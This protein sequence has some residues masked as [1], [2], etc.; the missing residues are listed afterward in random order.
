MVQ[1]ERRGHVHVKVVDGGPLLI[2]YINEDDKRTAK[3]IEAEVEVLRAFAAAYTRS[4]P[5]S[6]KAITCEAHL[7]KQK[8][9][10][11]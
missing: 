10:G 3:V 8:N 4:E 11:R 5:V 2:V 9:Q 6:A 1:H 7:A